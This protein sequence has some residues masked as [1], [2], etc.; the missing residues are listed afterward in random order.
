VVLEFWFL[1]APGIQVEM[2][3]GVYVNPESDGDGESNEKGACFYLNEMTQ[4][5]IEWDESRNMDL[6]QMFKSPQPPGSGSK[7]SKRGTGTK[8]SNATATITTNN[9]S[10][11]NTPSS[12]STNNS[13]LFAGVKR[14]LREIGRI[15]NA[16]NRI[17]DTTSST[18]DNIEARYA[19]SEPSL[20]PNSLEQM[21]KRENNRRLTKN[22]LQSHHIQTKLN[23][24]AASLT[25]RHRRRRLGYP[26]EHQNERNTSNISASANSASATAGVVLQPQFGTTSTD[27]FMSTLERNIEPTKAK[28]SK[29][30][31]HDD[32]AE[33]LDAITTPNSSSRPGQLSRAPLSPVNQNNMSSIPTTTENGTE[34]T[35]AGFCKSKNET[36]KKPQLPLPKT[37]SFPQPNFDEIPLNT[38]VEEDQMCKSHKRTPCGKVEYNP[39]DQKF[40]DSSGNHNDKCQKLDDDEFG[41]IEF[42]ESVLAKIDSL[43]QPIPS[44]RMIKQPERPVVLLPTHRDNCMGNRVI[45]STKTTSSVTDINDFNSKKADETN[46]SACIKEASDDEFGDFPSETDFAEIDAMVSTQ[47]IIPDVEQSAHREK[48]AVQPQ[49]AT[50]LEIPASGMDTSNTS[51]NNYKHTDD[52]DEFGSFPNEVD[53]SQ[54]DALVATQ[55]CRSK[56]TDSKISTEHSMIA[57]HLNKAKDN[58]SSLEGKSPIS[59]ADDE[60]DDFPDDIDFNF[61]DQVVTETMVAQRSRKIDPSAAVR[62]QRTSRHDSGE[63]SF[64][65]FSRYKVL[66]VDTD[67]RNSTKILRVATW[68]NSMVE[69]DEVIKKILKDGKVKKSEC[70]V[71]GEE[72]GCIF[73]SVKDIDYLEDGLLY[74]CG[75]WS[76]T[77][78][79]PGDVIHVCSL[80]GQYKT[81]ATALPIVLHSYPPPGSDVD[82]LILV[83][84]PDMLMSPSI[85]SEASSC[86]RRAALKSKIGSTGISSKAAFFGTMRHGL[87]EACMKTAEFDSFF[88]QRVIKKLLREKAEMLIGCNISESEAEVEILG[89]LPMIQQFAQEYTTLRKDIMMLSSLGKTVGGVACHPDIRLLVK[90]VHSVEENIVSASL[91]LKGSIDGVLEAESMTIGHKHNG[92]S[93]TNALNNSNDPTPQQSLM[94]LELKTGHNQNVQNAHMAQLSLYTFMLQSRYGTH[95]EL[96]GNLNTGPQS[97]RKTSVKGGAPG[98]ILLYLNDKSQQICHVS[99]RMNEVKTLMS[100]RNV[101]ASDSKRA[102]CPRGITLS[103]EEGN[104]KENEVYLT[105]KLLPAPTANLPELKVSSHSCKR[106]FSNREC[107][108]YAASDSTANLESHRDLLLQFTGHLKDEDLEYF[109][110]WDRLIDIEA[111]SSNTKASTPWLVDSRIREMEIGESISGMIFE[112]HSSYKVGTSRALVCFRRKTETCSQSSFENLNV[113]HGSQVIVSTD[114]TLLDHF[115]RSNPSKRQL[116]NRNH[117]TKGSIDRIEEDRV[118]VSTTY[119]EMNQIKLLSSRYQDIA[120]QSTKGNCSSDSLLFRLD[121]ST[122]SV[123]TGTLRWN[124]INFLTSDYAVRDKTECTELDRIKQRRLTWLRDVVI[125][126]KAPEFAEDSHSSLFH[127]ID[128]HIP[129][130][131]LLELSEEFSLLNDAQQMAVKKVMSGRDYTLIQGLPGTGKTSTLGFLARLLV[132][133][134]RRV[135]ITSYTHSA[136]DNIMSKLI[137]KGMGS[138]KSKS[139]MSA[140]VRLGGSRRPCHESVKPIIH[141]ELAL[142]LDK[143]SENRNTDIERSHGDADHPSAASLKEV[144]ATSRVLGVSA[145]S[146]PRSP[147][148]QSEIFDVVI[149]DEAGQMNEPTALGAL[150]AADSFVLIGDH[151]QLPP[152]VNSS[153]ADRGGY[154]ISILKRLADQHPHAIAPLTMQYRMNEAICKI[155]SESIYGGQ[156]R[157]GNDKVRSQLLNL[158]AF[159]SSL[160]TPTAERSIAWLHSVVDPEQPIVFVDTDNIIEKSYTGQPNAHREDFMALEGKAGGS[161]VNRT[162]AKLVWYI[163]EAMQLCGHDLS[164][165]GVISPFNAQIRVMEDNAAVVPWKKKGL[166]MSTIDKYQGRDK[167]TIILSLVRSNKNNKAGRLLQDARRLN[168][169]F[170]RAKCKLI[171]IG[172]YRTL[173]KGSA[174]LKPILNRMDMR[175]QRFKLP[176]NALGCYNIM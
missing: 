21:Q 53:F 52:E 123:G 76:F 101:V 62:N 145:L 140:L 132:A 103:F 60:F 104:G 68:I 66:T 141:S 174:P 94:C 69:S 96:D 16:L 136:V 6:G 14:Q 108:L 119:D 80:T 113:K 25:Q 164:E 99:P 50:S 5:V 71:H 49:G 47:P 4:D 106:C 86:N 172:S 176:D 44:C 70:H 3:N 112:T 143:T 121:K 151:K 36:R 111:E 93:S 40:D 2:S 124:L 116:Q 161:I 72:N 51:C 20:S 65:K 87:F 88:A 165:I 117:I 90:G 131:N 122:N 12:A 166:E 153:I 163:L 11:S 135:L 54:M 128:L 171:V 58:I 34:R 75:E 158:P 142:Q 38:P 97:P 137:D 126:L 10:K 7:V 89:V 22:E 85:I 28:K 31:R 35:G 61:L 159:P 45:V 17:D 152:L 64:M 175:K 98:G 92:P 19:F 107:M 173:S 18:V 115:T 39:S 33:L 56:S 167:S 102:L 73:T 41:E 43:T 149:I 77:P 109:R 156:L 67:Q 59:K 162:E 147:L 24:A 81:D 114:G 129:G 139:G 15:P 127:G 84:H 48:S 155:S 105:A 110:K 26:Q 13:S 9:G 30:A 46:H 168:V 29:V 79:T 146:L 55:C 91:G 1:L 8:G 74:L 57:D 120:Q 150:A 42:S 118:F 148:L 133:R 134:G 27:N 100:Q 63:L 144:I 160:P 23:C 78:V 170:T 154:G 157:C 37:H 32:F 138:R 169:A 82:D 130:C 95:V 83:L 125:R